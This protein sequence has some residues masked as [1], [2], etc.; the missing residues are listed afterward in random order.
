VGIHSY[1]YLIALQV[2]S[3]A[4]QSTGW[5]GVV[6]V[7]AN[8]FGKGRRG[9]I[10]GIWNSHTSIGNIVG[11]TIAA[12]FVEDNWGLSF[13]V[14]GIIMSALGVLMFFILVPTPAQA[15]FVDEEEQGQEKKKVEEEKKEEEKAVGMLEAARI[16]GVMEF[17]L[18]LFFAK[19]VAYTFLYWLPNYIHIM[20][21][22][23]AE[24]AGILA[25]LFDVGGIVGG[26]TCGILSD[27]TRK[28]ATTCGIMLM[29]AVPCLF[30]Y[31]ALV[32]DW[33]PITAED[34]APL[35]DSCFW[36]NVAM[37]MIVGFFVNGPYCLITTAVSAELGQHPSL[38]GS[39]KALA[40][41]TAL[42]DGTGSIG[43]AVGPLLAGALSS[44][45]NWDNVFYML[46]ASDV[47]A[48]IL[49]TRI[50]VREVRQIL[51]K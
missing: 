46:I 27:R 47:I 35:K 13:I 21:K 23:D 51:G 5:P 36:W 41:V 3:G 14:P 19:L 18:C 38:Q 31:Q 34:G 45:D 28:P 20:Y 30:I 17:S 33:C 42:I 44:N 12:V 8:W 49:L 2:L 29:M 16:P 48:L 10:M 26:I 37:T 7:L 40:T 43:A 11:N 50:I 6:T 22:V 32:K 1:W 39:S 15:G 24:Q 4:V 25:D 9:L